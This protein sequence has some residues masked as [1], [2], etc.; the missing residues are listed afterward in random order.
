MGNYLWLGRIWA[1]V[2]GEVYSFGD[3]T[4]YS[5]FI[6][7]V[8]KRRFV[9][10]QWNKYLSINIVYVPIF[11]DFDL[12]LNSNEI[13]KLLHDGNMESIIEN[14]IAWM[15]F[16]VALNKLDENVGMPMTFSTYPSW[17]TVGTTQQS[18][19]K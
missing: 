9:N 11:L 12:K 6:G 1:Q 17:Y 15:N 19:W 2:D 14:I 3:F 16:K 5:F 13:K 4:W 18:K 10:N 8:I 7:F